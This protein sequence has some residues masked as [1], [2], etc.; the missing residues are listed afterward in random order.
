MN[1][2]KTQMRYRELDKT[3]QTA[4]VSF[5]TIASFLQLFGN[6]LS[7]SA[8]QKVKISIQYFTDFVEL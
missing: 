6:F 1:F 5:M 7:N 4:K 2:A 8:R 3:T